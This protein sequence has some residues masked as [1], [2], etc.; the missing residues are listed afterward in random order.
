MDSKGS[1]AEQ[2]QRL[3]NCGF[4]CGLCSPYIR[5]FSLYSPILIRQKRKKLGIWS[6]MLIPGDAVRTKNGQR[7]TH[8]SPFNLNVYVVK[9]LI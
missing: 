2:T 8:A 6:E 3:L 7:G 5:L 4:A 1:A 9:V